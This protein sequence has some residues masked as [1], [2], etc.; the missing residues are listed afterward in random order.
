[1]GHLIIA[2]S[3]FCNGQLTPEEIHETVSK[4][5]P[6]TVVHKNMAG[7]VKK[8]SHRMLPS[9]QVLL[10]GQAKTQLLEGLDVPLTQPASCK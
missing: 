8:H 10:L 2:V 4:E 7:I 3:S 9:P 5:V 6:G 1:M